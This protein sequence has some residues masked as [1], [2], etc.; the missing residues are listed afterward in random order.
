MEI[1]LISQRD[2]YHLCGTHADH[3]SWILSNGKCFFHKNDK[4]MNRHCRN[5]SEE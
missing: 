5:I 4:D 2:Q 1:K 3:R